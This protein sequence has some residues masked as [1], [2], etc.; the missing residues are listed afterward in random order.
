[1]D[2]PQHRMEEDLGSLAWVLAE[3][4]T[5]WSKG[6]EAL[7]QFQKN[8]GDTTLL[9]PARNQFH[10]ICGVLDM[11]GS[12]MPAMVLRHGEVAVE[13]FI[14]DPALCTDKAVHTLEQAGQA[15]AEYMESLLQGE[16]TPALT[17]F[18]PYRNIRTLAASIPPAS[19]AD[20]WS[21][22]GELHE[23]DIPVPTKPLAPSQRVRDLID[24]MVLK[25]IQGTQQHEAAGQLVRIC[26]GLAADSSHFQ[27]RTFWKVAAGFFEALAHGTLA[28]D[29]YVK[30]TASRVLVQYASMAEDSTKVIPKG[31]Q[32]LLFFCAQAQPDG[33][34]P[35]P[36]LDAVRTAFGLNRHVPF[37]Y[38]RQYFWLIPAHEKEALDKLLDD[39]AQSCSDIGESSTHGLSQCLVHFKELNRRLPPHVPGSADFTQSLVDAAS[40]WASS[41]QTP[42]HALL[43]EIAA[44]ILYVQ[45]LLTKRGLHSL[46][47][48]QHMAQLHQRLESV[49]KTGQDL[50]ITPWMEALYKQVNDAHTTKDLANELRVVLAEVEMGLDV[51]FQHPE[52][53]ATLERVPDQL[54]QIHNIL[55]ILGLE[56]AALVAQRVSEQVQTFI[57]QTHDSASTTLDHN[58]ARFA[59]IG[60]NIGALGLQL[61]MLAYQ[62]ALAQNLFVYDPD[63]ASLKPALNSIR[64]PGHADEDFFQF[65][66]E[67]PQD[68]P[69]TYVTGA[70]AQETDPVESTAAQAPETATATATATAQS[71]IP[72][73]AAAIGGTGLS[74]LPPQELPTEQSEPPASATLPPLTLPPEEPGQTEYKEH[75][76][77]V[78]E[79]TAAPT[80]VE[81]E[82][83]APSE[84]ELPALEL[85][86]DLGL[87]A[88]SI[89]S[90]AADL[91]SD[92]PEIAPTDTG[93]VFAPAQHPIALP[94]GGEPVETVEAV[95]ATPPPAEAEAAP[96][97]L[98]EDD[99]DL[100]GIFLDEAQGVIDHAQAALAQLA[101]APA[102]TEQQT[103]LR[104][105]LHTL[106]GSSRMVGLMEFGEAAWAM[107]QLLNAWLA[108]QKPFDPSIQALCTQVLAAMNNWVADIYMR[109]HAHWQAQP[110]IES[111][112]AMRLQGQYIPLA[113]EDQGE[114]IAPLTSHAQQGTDRD[115]DPEPV[116]STTE[117]VADTIT[118]TERPQPI[119]VAE[120]PPQ[121]ASA[122]HG[123]ATTPT[124][125][126][127]ET[128]TTPPT[129]WGPES[130]LAQLDGG[131]AATHPYQDVLSDQVDADL[132]PIFEEEAIDLLP[133]LVGALRRWADHPAHS[134][135]RREAL[136]ILHTLKGS[137]R[138]AGAMHLGEMA[139][140]FESSI[141]VL[142]TC[143]AHSIA[144]LLTQYDH[145]QAAFDAL[146][147]KTNAALEQGMLATPNAGLGDIHAVYDIVR[148][149]PQATLVAAPI[150]EPVVA[151]HPTAE[152]E[153]SSDDAHLA[154]EP[155]SSIVRE[156]QHA[157]DSQPFAPEEAQGPE[158]TPTESDD[159]SSHYWTAGRHAELP[160]PTPLDIKPAPVNRQTLRV[161]SDLINR[162][163][164]QA[165]EIQIARARAESRLKQLSHSLKEMTG[166]LERLRHQLRELEVQAESQM[167]SRMSL[168]KEHSDFDPLEFDR[169]TRVQEL[170]RM[171]AETVNDVA[172]V[173]RGLQVTMSGAED[174]LVE[175]GMKGRELQRDLLRS[176]MVE[177]NSIT[178]RLHA[179]VRQAALE[180]GKQ[181]HLEIDGGNIEID[182]SLLDRMTPA[183]EHLLRNCVSH[184]IELPEERLRLRKPE[185]GIISIRVSQEGNDVAFEFHDD[186]KGLDLPAIR[187]KGLER[188][189]IQA[190]QTLSD[191]ELANLI[192]LPGFTTMKQVTGLAGRGIGMDVVRT[193]LNTVGGRIETSTEAQRGSTF[194]MVMPLTTAVTQVMLVRIGNIT[195]GIPANQVENIHRADPKQLS[196]A[197]AS[198]H[199]AE[200]GVLIPFYWAGALLQ[201]S[202][203][204]TE[205]IEGTTPI[206]LV[207]S[208]S[209][210]L[211]LHVDEIIGNQEVVVKNLGPQIASIDGLTGMSVL[212]SGAILLIYNFIA[213]NK[214]H[215]QQ[216][217]DTRGQ[218]SSGTTTEHHMPARGES[219]FTRSVAS[220]LPLVLVVDDSIT[221]RRVTQRLLKREG[222]RVE[223][224]A[225][226]VQALEKLKQERPTVVLSDIE[227][228]K[229]DGFELLRHIRAQAQWQ[230]LPIIMITSRTAQKHKERANE[231][232][233]NH[234]LGKPYSDK[235]L[236]A[237]VGQYAA[238]A[239]ARPILPE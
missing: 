110:F 75:A 92:I 42:S 113:S 202:V 221:V 150:P 139:H 19:P 196:R 226:G 115:R 84:P 167:Q 44:D 16:N 194:R 11:V 116:A 86:F 157:Y 94:D 101:L 90:P 111:A 112:D 3:M 200:T 61:D 174:D 153:S 138:L 173:Q 57:A 131:N 166:S 203:Q 24:Q 4:R 100:L 13:R 37:D 49:R 70:E 88:L 234:Y 210:R 212:A 64:S 68:V 232:G 142:E 149:T 78:S 99:D 25:I 60:N 215:G 65:V 190:E 161:R 155:D 40:D 38:N 73:V 104:R 147:S 105:A 222:Y 72:L 79:T 184:G 97:A 186:G 231:L 21:L 106:K 193:E 5:T 69:S 98:E 67:R 211:A 178:E 50:P 225:D 140:E 26:L 206:I 148:S 125:T 31:M 204:S 122:V 108:G 39:I 239:Q 123:K 82:T 35:S 152:E 185:I 144:P 137:S 192:F 52:N 121:E 224:A 134:D 83:P 32:D 238:A 145:L 143:D 229:M 164:N 169:F 195:L 117:V 9:E 120:A 71:V 136:R 197:Y 74:L 233:A 177:F 118:A 130:E 89:E 91:P 198:R 209:Q 2:T 176:R 6:I 119:P 171:M 216:T 34:Q 218:A 12:F 56:Q 85:D 183:F 191:D 159:D 102:D 199:F 146:R 77:D 181:I 168:G 15:V 47:T 20:L 227:M 18:L 87:S 132:F 151:S 160:G 95:E 201:H 228:P 180:T 154:N 223:L 48:E 43:L 66:Q 22:E 27:A 45:A 63:A 179:L 213:L 46:D 23:P 133:Q 128:A 55:A 36:I 109:D 170:T 17:L 81:A 158:P 188:G 165:G 129:A 41:G 187:A 220:N 28:S 107:E 54:Q 80:A 51:F 7:R 93:A 189:L 59:E 205:T 126:T 29:I 33:R 53:T 217:L 236:L 58:D 8:P 30:R 235:E 207:R 10:Q 62:P 156:E 208:A 124:A 1:M 103:S 175:Q 114:T 163:I 76:S 135:A 172:T 182:R 237:L 214:S 96:A 141:G 230:D 219:A 14:A 162:L 127:P